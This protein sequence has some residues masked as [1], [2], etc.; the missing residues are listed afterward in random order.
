MAGFL[1]AVALDL[2]GTLAEND[3]VS[4]AAIAQVD[5]L[6][7]DGLAAVLVTGRIAAELEAGFP[8]LREHFDAAVVENGAVVL[9]GEAASDL[10]EP[11]EDAL[12]TRLVEQGIAVRRGRVLLA[13]DAQDAEAVVAAAGSLGLDCQVVRNRAALMVLPAG[14]SKGT[15]LLAALAE[16]GISS[17]NVIAIGDAENDLALLHVAE[18]GV[19]VGNAVASVREHA[20]LVLEAAD[21]EG[22]VA[23]LTGPILSGEQVIGSARRR[24]AL[25]RFSDGTPATVPAWPANVLVCGETGAGKSYLAGLLIEEWISAGYAVFVIDMEGDHVALDSLHNTIV[26]DDQPSTQELASILRQPSL[27]VILDVSALEL[28]RR[29]DYVRNVSAV[30]EP[31]R[32]AWGLPHWIVVD[33]AHTALS[34]G[35]IAADIFRPSDRGYCLVTYQPEQLCAEAAA[36]IDVTITAGPP[37]TST[38]SGTVQ[39]AR[40]ATLCETGSAERQF[41][42]GARRT[43]HVRHRHKYAVV[44][45]PEHRWFRFRSPDGHVVTAAKNIAEFSHMLREVDT[46]VI[47]HHLDHG[48]FSRWILGTMQ[49]RDLATSIG[50]IERSFITR[51][52][53]DLLHA[54]ER[55]HEEVATR[56]GLEGGRSVG[57]T[58]RIETDGWKRSLQQRVEL[59]I[60]RSNTLSARTEAVAAQ[61]R[62]MH[63]AG[64]ATPNRTPETPNPASN[65]EAA[66]RDPLAD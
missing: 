33:E 28:P 30:I 40:T 51:R 64:K 6:R 17:H 46:D 21:G 2:D 41:T 44:S 31:E 26:L 65:G 19:A 12:A 35:G 58:Q 34:D 9:V 24:V 54:R 7:D 13:G 53:A 62:H 56:Y 4:E 48:D 55:M 47:R 32:A 29:L 8:G 11:V 61:Y 10:A 14:V 18:V 22:V 25:G 63:P 15:G 5:K 27:S 16:L 3:V 42:V 38:R 37:T 60:A 50:A 36:A 43:P 39:V 66:A 23:L 1:R 57:S 52:A 49:D 20:D 45:L 59:A